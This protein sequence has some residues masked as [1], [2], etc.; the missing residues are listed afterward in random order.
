M[1][2]ELGGQAFLP[3]K[4]GPADT[5]LIT[6]DNAEGEPVICAIVSLEIPREPRLRATWDPSSLLSRWGRILPKI[7]F[8]K[9]NNVS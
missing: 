1:R 5:V 7:V 3:D 6:Y 9:D 4:Q 2:F 8:L